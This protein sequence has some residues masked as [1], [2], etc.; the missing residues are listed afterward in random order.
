MSSRL[1]LLPP[2]RDG[3]G[4]A[5]C[6]VSQ[7]NTMFNPV[8]TSYLCSIKTLSIVGE[9]LLPQLTITLEFCEFGL[10]GEDFVFTRLNRR[11]VHV[12]SIKLTLCCLE[13]LLVLTTT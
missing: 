9:L 13:L 2:T 5:N 7:S 10:F 3:E 4:A 1:A 8:I 12:C 11:H 6:Q